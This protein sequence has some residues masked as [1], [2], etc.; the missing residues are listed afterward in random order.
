MNK[1]WE[2]DESYVE[3]EHVVSVDHGPAMVVSSNAF[4]GGLPVEWRETIPD[5]EPLKQ[6]EVM[7]SIRSWA[8]RNG[9]SECPPIKAS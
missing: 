5:S 8:E 3:I 9:Y 7:S 4:N 1:R 2:K 6:E